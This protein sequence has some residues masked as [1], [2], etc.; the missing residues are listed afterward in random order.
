MQNPTEAHYQALQR[1]LYC[2]H[3]IVGQGILLHTSDQLSLSS[4]FL[5]RI[6]VP[7]LILV[8]LLIVIF[9]SL[10]NPLSSGNLRNKKLFPAPLPKLNIMLWPLRPQRWHGL[11]IFLRNWVFVILNL[12]LFIVIINPLSTLLIILSYMIVPNT[13]QSIV[14]LPTK[15]SWKA[16]YSLLTSL[17]PIS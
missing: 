15:W 3:P 12:S 7:V 5:T 9:F 4:H 6:G 10:V 17:H 14:T 8:D 13:L 2:I 1:N 16:Y 11:F